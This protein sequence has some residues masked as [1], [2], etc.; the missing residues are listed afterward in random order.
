M[1]RAELRQL[2]RSRAALVSEEFQRRY[3]IDPCVVVP[4]GVDHERFQGPFSEPMS[5][6]QIPKPRVFFGGKITQLF[7][8]ALFNEV[9]RR[10]DS[11][12]FLLAGQILDRAVWRR[13]RKVRNVHY[14]GDV[15]YDEY[16]AYVAAS[17]AC[18]L[19]YV[20]DRKSHGANSIKLYEYAAA[21]KRTISTDGN[22]ALALSAFVTIAN[23]ADEFARAIVA[24]L[25]AGGRTTGAT[26]AGFS[27][28]ER[29]RAIAQRMKGMSVKVR[30]TPLAPLQ[31][32][33]A[34]HE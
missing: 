17:D 19:P 8:F 22:G 33:G 14:L 6:E 25:E 28:D 16:P 4:N 1:G 11:V 21:G 26:E 32:A 2:C 24:S 7:D 31:V 3:M 20:R 23:S 10:L 9:A 5:F 30:C 13:I 12:Q 18:I 34:E 27:W 29:A 15:H